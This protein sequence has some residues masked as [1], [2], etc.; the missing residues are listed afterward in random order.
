MADRIGVISKGEIILVEE[1]RELMRQLGKKQLTLHL[2][3]PLERI[4]STLG[5]YRLDLS[6]DCLL[7]TSRCV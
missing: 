5:A 6:S 4:P 3:T 1:K 7:Y 2:Q